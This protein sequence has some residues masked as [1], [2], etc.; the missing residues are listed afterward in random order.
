MAER[1]W[2]RW[3]G[4]LSWL[5]EA[6]GSATSGEEDPRPEKGAEAA[7]EVLALDKAALWEEVVGR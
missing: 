1:A 4:V 7:R 3:L 5:G 2:A 6:R